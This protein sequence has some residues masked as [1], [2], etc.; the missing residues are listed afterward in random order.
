MWDKIVNHVVQVSASPLNF[1][2][3]PERFSYVIF[4]TEAVMQ[5]G[6]PLSNFLE[7]GCINVRYEWMNE[8]MNE[9][10][11]W[12]VAVSCCLNFLCV[13]SKTIINAAFL[14]CPGLKLAECKRWRSY[15]ALEWA[16]CILVH[17][18]EW[19]RRHG[20]CTWNYLQLVT[21][22]SLNRSRPRPK[23]FRAM[24]SMV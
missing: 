8:W 24:S 7:E 13:I 12:I 22:T 20:T 23:Y 4:S 11:L 16:T 3:I 9:W 14:L 5:L 15:I 21:E 19:T 6:A 10:S 17:H 1:A 18:T 2:C